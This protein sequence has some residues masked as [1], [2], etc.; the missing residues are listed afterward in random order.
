MS[1]TCRLA[2]FSSFSMAIF[3]WGRGGGGGG[4]GGMDTIS[5]FISV[6][7]SNLI[8]KITYI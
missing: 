7:K 6:A 3:I 2:A 1:I 4:G 8:I 5:Q